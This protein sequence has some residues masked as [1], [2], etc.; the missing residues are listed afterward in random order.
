[1]DEFE[2]NVD[3]EAGTV[4]I[5]DAFKRGTDWDSGTDD[6]GYQNPTVMYYNANPAPKEEIPNGLATAAMILGIISFFIPGV[7]NILAIIFGGVGISKA[8][9]G[10]TGKNKAK[11][12]LVCGIIATA[13]QIIGYILW[14]TVFSV[15]I[16]GAAAM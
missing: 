4:G 8:N 11:A 5:D 3:F 1:M 16:A 10:A 12:G 7:T 6:I 14:A 15:A 13:L 2:K 9:K